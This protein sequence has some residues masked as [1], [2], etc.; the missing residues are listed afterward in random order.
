MTTGFAQTF[1]RLLDYFARNLDL[2]FL[3]KV[4]ERL[5]PEI[6]F[7]SVPY[8]NLTARRLT[9]ADHQHVRDFL[10]LRVADLQIHLLRTVIQMD[11]YTRFG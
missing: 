8:R 1:R 2:S 9:L 4:L 10:H 3:N 11:P 7:F 5:R 6:A